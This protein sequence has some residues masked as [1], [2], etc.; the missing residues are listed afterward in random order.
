MA[1]RALHWGIDMSEMRTEQ[2]DCVAKRPGR[3]VRYPADRV[4][5]LSRYRSA[6]AAVGSCVVFAEKQPVAS[7]K[8]WVDKTSFCMPSVVL[9]LS[10]LRVGV[11]SQA[12]KFPVLLCSL[13]IAKADRSSVW[14]NLETSL[15]DTRKKTISRFPG[16]VTALVKSSAL[17]KCS[18]PLRAFGSTRVSTPAPHCTQ[19]TKNNL[20]LN[21]I[22]DKY[23]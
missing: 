5:S 12:W 15:S 22:L 16:K 23:A 7:E 8:P 4:A 1:S 11:G 14:Q 3:D 21:K 18:S 6:C 9:I 17:V 10:N 20:H 19:R 2:F 13:T